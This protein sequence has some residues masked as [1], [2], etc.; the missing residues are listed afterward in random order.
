MTRDDMILVSVDDH[1]IEPPNAFARH[2]PARF[3]GREPKTQQIGGRDVWMFE[4][5][6][7]GYMGLNS[8]VGRPKEEYGMEPLSYEHMRRGTWDIKAR[9]EDM[10]ANGVLGSICFPTFPGFAGQKFQA[11]PDRDIALA[12]IQAYNDW[13]LHDWAN[14]APGRFIPL[15]LVPMWDIP[16]AVAEVKRLSAQGV[17]AMSF[18]DNPA[19][20]GYPSIHDDYW[21]PLWKVCADNQVVICCHIGTGAHAEHASDLSP[22]DAWITSMPISIS[23]SAADWIWAP[24]WKKYPDLK[25][26]L[27]EGGIGWIPYLLERA[28]FTHRHHNAWTG[29]NFEGQMPSDI[30]R[31]HIITCFIED[32]F[33]LDNLKYIGED[34]VTWECDYPHSD[35]TWPESADILWNDV[36]HLP[37]ETIHKITHLNTMREFSYDPFSILGRENCTVGALKARA[38]HVNTL[39]LLGLGGAK[40]VT[41]GKGPVTSGDIQKMFQAAAA[42]SAL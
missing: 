5:K 19:L 2:M 25:M 39:P 8:V 11:H 7:W 21:D 36:K 38:K 12:A 42:E 30:F 24:M 20:L 34:M 17:H 31:K 22:I 10:D 9:V 13:H 14:A 40:P 26:A 3:K 1:V 33:G 28:D 32:R 18:S 23:N 41:S 15:C 4:G 16:A 29:S 6:A 27:S 37:E 35:C